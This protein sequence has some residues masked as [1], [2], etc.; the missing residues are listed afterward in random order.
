[1]VRPH[2]PTHALLALLVAG[3]MCIVPAAEATAHDIDPEREVLV[4]VFADHVDVMVVYTEAPGERTDWFRLRWGLAFGD[5]FQE[6]LAP[7]AGRAIAPRVLDGLQFEVEGQQPRTDDPQV[8]ID[9][10]DQQLQIATY[11]RYEVD[12]LAEDDRRT[13]TVRTLDQPIPATTVLIYEGDDVRPVD[14][15]GPPGPAVELHRDDQHSATF[16]RD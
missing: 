7:L 3:L 10:D 15:T 2:H 13:V 6:A 4:Q 5:Q 12:E 11:A 1:M 9:D 8:K 16:T 14:D